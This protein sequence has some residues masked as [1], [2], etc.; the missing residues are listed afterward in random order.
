MR[1]S[2]A[3]GIAALSLSLGAC[4]PA[5]PAVATPL[6][7]TRAYRKPDV[8]ATFT[9]TGTRVRVVTTRGLCDVEERTLDRDALPKPGATSLSLLWKG[10]DTVGTLAGLGFA[11][12]SAP[13]FVMG[14]HAKT[15]TD[16]IEAYS[17]ATTFAV[18]GAIMLIW[19]FH[20]AMAV[21]RVTAQPTAPKV[22]PVLAEAWKNG[23]PCPQA[24]P[25]SRVEVG[26]RAPGGGAYLGKTDH[27]G[28]LEVDLRAVD[29]EPL[30]DA[31][32]AQLL[33]KG[34]EA[35]AIDLAEIQRDRAAARERQARA[36]EEE[37]ARAYA[38]VDVL[39]C[40]AQIE[41]ACAA[42]S[43]HLLRFP[44][45]P[46]VPVL[47]E[48]LRLRAAAPAASKPRSCSDACLARCEGSEECAKICQRRWCK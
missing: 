16:R 43:Q 11:G 27:R 48:A 29:T 7:E 1:R 17:A 44:E 3:A 30:G 38:E 41:L 39:A 24:E 34:R 5:K 33:V 6:R 32:R 14:A 45:G 47:H 10:P 13:F 23:V 12:V 28:V 22:N 37:E 31:A 36:A 42:V 26:L 35:G 9:Q 19:A 8:Q 21:E 46:H 18:T 40:L 20:D 2:L 25:A 4:A 15:S